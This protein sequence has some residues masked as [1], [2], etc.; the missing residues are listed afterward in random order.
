M[1]RE[2][3][4]GALW[5][6]STESPRAPVAKGS[7]VVDG[8]EIKVVVW[9]NRWKDEDLASPDAAIRDAATRKPDLYIELDKPRP[10][11]G[12]VAPV[13]YAPAPNAKD[14]DMFTSDIPF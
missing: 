5:R 12:S 11:T 1:S 13:P 9:R 6:P 14:R 3:R 4:I 8:K 10:E 2:E 7:I